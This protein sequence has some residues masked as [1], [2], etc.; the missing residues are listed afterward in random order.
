ME[1]PKEG[2]TGCKELSIWTSWVAG[3]GKDWADPQENHD[4]SL[5]VVMRC[6]RR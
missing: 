5:S 6:S 3:K 1:H 2:E 4:C